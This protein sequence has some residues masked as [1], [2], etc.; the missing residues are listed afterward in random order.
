M[1]PPAAVIAF[2]LPF[3]LVG[4]DGAVHRDG[5]LRLPTQGDVIHVFK[6]AGEV[7]NP[8]HLEA[9]LLARMLVSLGD[10]NLV[11]DDAR[12]KAVVR[13]VQPD[14]EYL[15]AVYEALAASADGPRCSQCG[16]P[17]PLDT[18]SSP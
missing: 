7:E 6:V 15:N 13:L 5:L 17:T 1:T 10:M 4:P 9:L 8:A 14:V 11:D 2:R 18:S 12:M 3:G 16:R